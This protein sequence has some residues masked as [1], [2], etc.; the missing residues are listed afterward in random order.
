MGHT[1]SVEKG[2]DLLRFRSAIDDGID[3]GREDTFFAQKG[4]DIVAAAGRW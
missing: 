4:S 3:K 2:R 1:V